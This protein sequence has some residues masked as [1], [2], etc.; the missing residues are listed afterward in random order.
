[1]SP[2]VY[3]GLRDRAPEVVQIVVLKVDTVVRQLESSRSRSTEAMNTDTDVEATA[4]VVSVIRSKANLRPGATLRISYV[5]EERPMEAGPRAIPVLKEGEELHA[6]LKG[7][8]DTYE[9]AAMSA[10][11][12]R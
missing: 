8:P 10:S 3:E 7:G 4:R 11:F 6:Y 12:Q 9:P 2:R 5:S 1:M